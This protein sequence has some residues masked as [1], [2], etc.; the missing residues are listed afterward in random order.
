MLVKGDTLD[1]N[2]VIRDNT[3]KMMMC[4]AKILEDWLVKNISGPPQENLLLQYPEERGDDG[5][6]ISTY[7]LVDKE[8]FERGQRKGTRAR[9]EDMVGRYNGLEITWG[10]KV[11]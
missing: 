8:E 11:S 2:K 5:E 7:F 9:K 10:M 6:I 4:H 1:I 3:Y